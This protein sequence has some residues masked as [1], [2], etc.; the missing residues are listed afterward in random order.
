[1]SQLRQGIK[2]RKVEYSRTPTEFELTPYE[3]LMADIRKRSYKLNPTEIPP[4]VKTDAKDIILEFIRSRPP[5]KSASSR[6]L[7]P[8]KKDSTPMELLMEVG[9]TL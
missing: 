2:L 7:Q 9:K 4:K 5:L 6:V 3:M 8:K 1:M